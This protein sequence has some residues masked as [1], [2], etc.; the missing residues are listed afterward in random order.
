[1]Y[2]E[3]KFKI[4]GMSPLLMHNDQ[5]ADPLN[6]YAI[7]MK[8]ISKVRVKTDEHH[9][10]LAAIEWEASL[11]LEEQQI[12]IPGENIERMLI[13]AG[14]KTR[15]GREFTSGM[16]CDG[17][18]PLKYAGPGEYVKLYKDKNF[19]DRR[20]VKVQTSKVMRTRPIFNTWSLAF[21]VQFLPSILN[22]DAIKQALTTAGQIIGLC[23]YRP[24][25]GRFVV[26]N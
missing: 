8:K 1:M 24:K 9:A 3:L 6:P 5:M 16:M 26:I 15:L 23:D 25:F 10:H 19:V 14:K 4:E 12:V 22:A 7:E 13:D 21:A 18:W 2:Q 11:Y 20:A 17:S